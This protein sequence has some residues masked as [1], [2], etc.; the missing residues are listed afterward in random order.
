MML[1]YDLLICCFFFIKGFDLRIDPR[2]KGEEKTS[3]E[4]HSAVKQ[5]QFFQ[6]D[7]ASNTAGTRY[8]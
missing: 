8:F 1:I 7:V 3:C 2:I 6:T 4:Y 5:S